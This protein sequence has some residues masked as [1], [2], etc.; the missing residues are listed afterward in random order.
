MLPPNASAFYFKQK[1]DFYSGDVFQKMGCKH[2]FVKTIVNQN[3]IYDCK[4]RKIILFEAYK[5]IKQ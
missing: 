2:T 5:V 4:P 3:F 1:L